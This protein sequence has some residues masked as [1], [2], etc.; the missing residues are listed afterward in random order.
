[1]KALA[2]VVVIAAAGLAVFLWMRWNP[3]PPG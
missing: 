1:M 3:S 2:V